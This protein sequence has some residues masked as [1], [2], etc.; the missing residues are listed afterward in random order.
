M[1]TRGAS[2]SS[3]KVPSTVTAV[4]RPGG[5]TIALSGVPYAL[6]IATRTCRAFVR[7]VDGS[8]NV[9]DLTRGTLL[10]TV[11]VPNQPGYVRL[12]PA[13]AVDDRTQRVFVANSG[14]STDN[15]NVSMLDAA[16]GA[17]VRTVSPGVHPV[18]VAV[19]PQ[20]GWV[21]VANRGSGSVSILDATTGAVLRTIPVEG[22]PALVA[23]DARRA[24][25]FVAA[26]MGEHGAVSTLDETT[27]R[28]LRTVPIAGIPAVLVVAPQSGHVFVGPTSGGG[29]IAGRLS[30]LDATSG[31]VLRSL[32]LLRAQGVALGDLDVHGLA[33]DARTGHVFVAWTG[34]YQSEPMAS[35]V[36]MLNAATGALV[37]R[38]DVG[39]FP[40]AV[41]ADEQLGHA[42][43]THRDVV[44][45]TGDP[46]GNG[47]LSVL[48]TASGTEVDTIPVGW[49]PRQWLW[50]R[51][52]ACSSSPT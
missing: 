7:N 42:F 44:N 38:I 27:G 10:R 3:T 28:L 4:A 49:G 34:T 31:A 2:L 45:S 5:T 30:M 8:V 16:T 39:A 19:D 47:S 21:F 24:R 9:L 1:C 48:D 40:T 22:L 32:D 15:G 46:I 13:L 26:D 20:R 23:V 41:V 25:L 35:G 51:A 6:A 52:Q 12:A 33:V 14:D 17:V 18:A 50:T 29:A 11:H 37:K 43:V 36:S